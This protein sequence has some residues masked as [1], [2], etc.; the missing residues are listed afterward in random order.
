MNIPQKIRQRIKWKWND[1]KYRLGIGKPLR[2]TPRDSCIL[3]YHGI[4]AI[5]STKYNTRFIS[6]K[7][8]ER[9][10][11]FFAEN[12]HIVSLEE[13]YSG[14]F[15]ADKM[16]ICITFDDGYENNLTRA[17][18]VLEKY[19]IPA[20]FFITGIRHLNQ[21]V[22]WTDEIDLAAA[23][24]PKSISLLNTNFERNRKG[25]FVAVSTSENIKH[26]LRKKT[27]NEIE[28][29]LSELKEKYNFSLNTYH[30]DYY[31]TLTDTQIKG[32]S[33]NPLITIGAH[34]L[35]HADLTLLSE[36][37][38]VRE[39]RECRSYL[40]KII[41]KPVTS[42][43]FPFGSYTETVVKACETTGFIHLLALDTRA[44]ITHSSIQ[45]RFGVNP[46]I[47]FENQMLAIIA[48]KY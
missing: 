33:Q 13:Y 43:A 7:N 28:S 35:F 16:T 18:P 25:E 15:K 11:T 39:L 14:K 27:Q 30:P 36:E 42:L 2:F 45:A 37:E 5:G 8:F 9:Q 32:L 40:E 48:G 41:E 20:T 24:L 46:F 31:Q 26:F 17:L 1:L 44:D 38:C 10:M 6:E 47:S 22:L 21:S 4:D 12:C 3:V 29:A 19:K 23:L 34:G